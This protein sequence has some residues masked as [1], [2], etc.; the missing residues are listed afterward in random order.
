VKVSLGDA[1]WTVEMAIP[2]KSLAGANPRP[3][4]AV[5]FNICRDRYVGLSREWTSWSQVNANFHDPERF[6]HLVLSPTPQDLGKL[7]RELRQ[8][9]RRGP[10]LVFSNEGFSGASYAALAQ[11]AFAHLD[12]LLADLEK[13][14]REEHDADAARLLGDLIAESRRDAAALRT[15]LGD[16]TRVDIAAG[17]RTDT[18]VQ[19]LEGTLRD[20]IWQARLSALL[21]GI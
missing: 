18:A 14:R 17:T 13:T 3:G 2:W 21:S 12:E 19:K 8:G 20:A 5:G 9:D 16:L 6:A 7:A 4:A 11:A 10:I 15:G 1:S